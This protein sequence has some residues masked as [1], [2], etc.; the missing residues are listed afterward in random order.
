MNSEE[1]TQL[2]LKKELMQNTKNIRNFCVIAHVDHGKTS[3]V[4]NLISHNNIINPRLAGLIRYMDSLPDEQERC[5]TMKTSAISISY[6]SEI[7]NETFLINVI[8]SPGHVDFS[9]EIF[10]ALKVCEGALLVIDV[11]EGVCSQTISVLKQAW[12]ENVKIILVFNK[13]DRLINEIKV[14]S[15]EAYS[16]LYMLLE[17]VNSIMSSLID[18]DINNLRQ[19]NQNTRVKHRA[20]SNVSGNSNNEE[21]E[22]VKKLIEEKESELYFSPE[23]GNV[24]FASAGDSW[25]FSLS[26]FAKLYSEK[27]K[28]DA[29][30]LIQ[31]FWGNHYLNYKTKEFSSE[32]VG[33]N[34]KP[35]FVELI[36]DSIYK[37]YNMI[38]EEKDKEKIIKAAETFKIQLAQSDLSYLHKDTKPLLRAFMRQWLP[39]PY[40]IFEIVADKL[41]NPISGFKLKLEKFFSDTEES[42]QA[43]KSIYGRSRY[44]FDGLTQDEIK[45]L[46]VFGLILKMVTL[47]AKNTSNASEIK[48]FQILKKSQTEEFEEDDYDYISVPFAR[49]FTGTIHSS[50]EYFLVGPKHQPDL[51]KSDIVKVKFDRLYCFMGEHLELVDS[52]P[53]GSIFSVFGIDQHVF[54]TA[55]ICEVDYFPLINYNF[56]FYSLIKV[57]V[58]TEVNKNMPKLIR[59]LKRLHKSDPAIEY[60]VQSTGEHIIETSGEVHLERAIKDLEERL[61]KCKLI[62]SPPII[63]YREGLSNTTYNQNIQKNKKKVKKNKKNYEIIDKNESKKKEKYELESSAEEDI[64]K[65]DFE[66]EAKSSNP[67]GKRAEFGVKKPEFKAKNIVL[68]YK[69]RKD[70]TDF[71]IEKCLHVKDHKNE[72]SSFYEVT[73][74]SSTCKYCTIGIQSF[75]LTSEV[76]DILEKYKS[77]LEK[78]NLYSNSHMPQFLRIEKEE[79]R[80][81]LVSELEKQSKRTAELINKYSLEL[82]S[83][84]NKNILVIRNLP[85]EF[86]FFYNSEEETIEKG[87][88]EEELASTE[89]EKPGMIIEEYD[90]SSYKANLQKKINIED[91]KIQ[92]EIMPYLRNGLSL[93]EFYNSVRLGW[94]LATSKI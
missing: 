90:E 37:L 9:S 56:N 3:L 15:S 47:P 68:D 33:R 66:E 5:I 17:K 30:E 26:T 59:G 49:C 31:H 87:K 20:N 78:V 77:T 52:V 43:L 58:S 34:S 13:I 42:N 62:V 29:N 35:L 2:D 64:D 79:L 28:I 7:S 21:N 84:N 44:N 94:R 12:K 67:V 14:T 11:V 6:F 51:G 53:P 91:E 32:P 40:A 19:K 70:N 80:K 18:Y 39:I 50:K 85:D 27:L 88:T 4:D 75:G 57:C 72:V 93:Y 65:Y 16:H 81:E 25:A 54:K 61:C 73:I 63:D 48:E 1:P 36:L 82:F 83:S 76:I 45:N 38:N 24:I 86:S 69:S 23:K 60:Y 22:I 55:L 41:P 10:T 74:N 71:Y 92:A 8:D 89:K 46:S